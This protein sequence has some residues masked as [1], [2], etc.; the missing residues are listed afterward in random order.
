MTLHIITNNVPRD[1]IDAWE[2]TPK[3]REGFDYLDWAAIEDGRDSAE[4]VR[5]RDWIYDLSEFSRL[6]PEGDLKGWS[7]AAPDSYF[8]GVLVR[9]VFDE[10]DGYDGQVV[11]GRY[12]S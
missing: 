4:F 10:F 1:T 6:S 5:Y 12:Y 7:G 2:L 3:E 9:F 8:S 11:V